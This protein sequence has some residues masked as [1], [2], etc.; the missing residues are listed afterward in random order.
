[1][2]VKRTVAS[3]RSGSARP[4]TGLQTSV[5]KRTISVWIR[6]DVGAQGRDVR[7][8]EL[9]QSAPRKPLCDVSANFYR[10]HLIVAPVHD[11][12]GTQPSGEHHGCRS[13]CSWRRAPR[14]SADGAVAK[15]LDVRFTSSSVCM[16]RPRTRHAPHRVQSRRAA[17]GS[18]HAR[19]RAVGTGSR[20]HIVRRATS[21]TSARCGRVCRAN[22]RLM[23]ALRQP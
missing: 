19:R 5:R 18:L 21:E 1:M 8:R 15:E 10:Q 23:A 22:R 6:S 16:P 4:A 7:H 9:G 2:S 20:P 12:A 11:S 14:A 17:P 3:M 13:P